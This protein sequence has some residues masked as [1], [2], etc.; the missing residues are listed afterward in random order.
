MGLYLQAL[1]CFHVSMTH[2]FAQ[3]ECPLYIRKNMMRSEDVCA[4]YFLTAIVIFL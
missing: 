1:T 2:S 4:K 3:Y